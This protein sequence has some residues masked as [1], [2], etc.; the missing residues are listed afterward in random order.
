MVAGQE[1]ELQ[2]P[3]E[4]E[5]REPQRG[6]IWRQIAV[7]LPR[8]RGSGEVQSQQERTTIVHLVSRCVQ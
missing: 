8:A 4:Q 2:H 6:D 3:R 1:G 7:L 5:L